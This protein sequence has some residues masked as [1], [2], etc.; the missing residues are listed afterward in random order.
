MYSIYGLI[1]PRDKALRYVGQTVQELNVRLKHH[2]KPCE[3]KKN[4]Y[5]SQWIKGLIKSGLRPE[6]FLIEECYSIHDLNE[7]EIFYIEYFKFIGS[8]LVNLTP[9]GMGAPVGNQN[10]KGHRHSEDSKRKISKSSSSRKNNLG[11]SWSNDHKR[12]IAVNNPRRKII[13][14]DLGNTYESIAEASRKLNIPSFGIR[15]ILNGKGKSYK[16]RTFTII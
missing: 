4:N 7:A 8:R 13:K 14:D 6:I 15:R 11:K 5:K 12:K 9:G 10:A 1:D 16:G 3:I 2:I